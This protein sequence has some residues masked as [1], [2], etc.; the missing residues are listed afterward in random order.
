MYN[1]NLI[2]QTFKKTPVILGGIEAS[3]RR[4]AHYD[5]WENKVKHSI[6][7]DSGA[8]LISYG[9]GEHSIIEIAEALDSGIPVSEITYVAGTVYKCRDLS[10]TYEPIILP[11]FDEVQ[12]DKLAYARS[13]AIQYQNTDPFT[14][15]TMAEFYGTKGLRDP[16]STCITSYTGGDG[17]CI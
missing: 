5:Y 16:E 10:R 11:S 3:L 17:R 4:M 6:L 14:A 12:A 15:G 7:I 8:D 2:R 1:S 9:M 13:F